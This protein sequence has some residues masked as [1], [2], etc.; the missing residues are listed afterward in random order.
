MTAIIKGQIIK[1][2]SKFAKNL[3]GDRIRLSTLKGE[4]NL[5]NLELDEEAL[6]DLLELPS[7]MVLTKAFCNKVSVKIPWTKLKTHPICIYLDQVEVELRTCE[8]PRTSTPSTPDAKQTPAATSKYGFVEKTVDGVFVSINAINGQFVSNT[9]KAD[10]QISRFVVQSVSPSTWQPTDLRMTRIK[11]Q[12]RGETLL[13]KMVEWSTIRLT[14]D[15]LDHEGGRPNTPIRIITNQG[16]IHITMKKKLSDC[17]ILASKLSVLLDDI[18]WVLTDSQIKAVIMHFRSLNPVIQKSTQQSKAMANQKQ[19][20]TSVVKQ[21]VDAKRPHNIKNAKELAQLQ[22]FEQYDL[23]ETSYHFCTQRIDLHLCDEMNRPEKESFK[24]RVDGGAMQLTLHKLFVDYYPFHTASASREHWERY[25]EAMKA[26]DKWVQA[27]LGH[28]KRQYTHARQ[29]IAKA[30]EQAKAAARKTEQRETANTNIEQNG[31]DSRNGTTL[32]NESV[33]ANTTTDTKNTNIQVKFDNTRKSSISLSD[34]VKVQPKPPPVPRT[35]PATKSIKLLA[36][37]AIIRISDF[38]I[39]NLSTSDRA[40][41]GSQSRLF[42]SDKKALFLPPEMSSVHIEYTSYYFPDGLDFPVPA[43][44]VFVQLN[45]FQFTLDY[46]TILWINQFVFNIKQSLPEDLQ[47]DPS[48]TIG[49]DHIDIRVDALMPKIIIPTTST[50]PEHPDRPESLL[51]QLSQLTASNCRIGTN[52]TRSELSTKLQQLYKSRLF[53]NN[54]Y[55]PNHVGDFTSLPQLLWDHAF[56]PNFF[57]PGTHNENLNQQEK[58]ERTESDSNFESKQES[59]EKKVNPNLK[60]MK[61]STYTFRE[62]SRKD[63]WCVKIDQIWADFVKPVEFKDRQIPFIDAV[64]LTIWVSFPMQL[65]DDKNKI[66][67]S[68][69]TPQKSENMPFSPDEK[70]CQM[71]IDQLRTSLL[72]NGSEQASN[73]VGSPERKQ[74]QN[75]ILNNKT[76]VKD[77]NQMELSKPKHGDMHLVVHTSEVVRLV[78]QHYQVLFLL[79]LQTSVQR[80]LQ[81]MEEDQLMLSAQKEIPSSSKIVAFRCPDIEATLLMAPAPSEDTPSED[82]S[83]GNSAGGLEDKDLTGLVSGESVED[84]NSAKPVN[85][86]TGSCPGEASVS[87]SLPSSPSIDTLSDSIPVNITTTSQNLFIEEK[88]NGEVLSVKTLTTKQT[89]DIPTEFSEFRERAATQPSTRNYSQILPKVSTDNPEVIIDSSN[90]HHLNTKPTHS[91]T[92]SNTDISNRDFP[93]GRVLYTS[94]TNRSTSPIMINSSLN[95]SYMMTNQPPRS[96]SH[97]DL[98]KISASSLSASFTQK[99][100]MLMGS[101]LSLDEVS[102]LGGFETETLSIQSDSSD[103]SFTFVNR[104]NVEM[105]SE[106]GLGSELSQS[107]PVLNGRSPDISSQSPDI[108]EQSAAVVEQSH[109]E[110]LENESADGAEQ[111]KQAQL[112]TEELYSN[113]KHKLNTVSVLK[114]SL[115]GVN[116]AVDLDN[117][118]M[119]ARIEIGAFEREEQGNMNYEQ[120]MSKRQTELSRKTSDASEREM[121]LQ[122]TLQSPVAKIR[123]ISGPGAEKFCETATDRGYA[124]LQVDGFISEFQKSTIS[125]LTGFVEDEIVGEAMPMKIELKNTKIQLQDD[126]P[127]VYITSPPP[128]PLDVNITRMTIERSPDGVFHIRDEVHDRTSDR[129]DGPLVFIDQEFMRNHNQLEMENLQ[130]KEQAQLMSSGISTLEQERASL[131]ATLEHLQEELLAADR[132]KEALQGKVTELLRRLMATKK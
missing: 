97:S 73:G 53:T 12:T 90:Q 74:D 30:Q 102:S 86:P 71:E 62:D 38:E 103:S 60:H 78:I 33:R 36:H 15:A 112:T 43:P 106:S 89:I 63:V 3:S 88:K 19:Q 39:Y 79:R 124:V 26:A 58:S 22:Y 80:L 116:V 20:T 119:A 8:E 52:S 55:F 34:E 76:D 64:P 69:E 95:V 44:N 114:V 16:Q 5:T 29:H 45:P 32:L 41:K 9:F 25:D 23:H 35:S 37:C 49:M 81:E 48:P 123:F 101:A 118:D 125:N 120:Y 13:F 132:Q 113:S 40:S 131:L 115:N 18:L 129:C 72:E 1:H 68:Q 107:L 21:E 108:I 61:L 70:K 117:N 10:I 105:D 82:I 50:V 6:M 59:D 66:S 75:T 121:L 24:R 7:W 85:S 65:N 31:P 128:I 17:D 77:V 46:T 27:I 14:I 122:A 98:A 56:Q 94:S 42:S 84:V 104:Q 54:L 111:S 126:M 99:Q 67:E 93:D 11:D 96:A 28:F 110:K 2:L 91:R 57:L 51:I 4:G 47:A 83:V 130:L 127:L 92:L 100:Q 87:S 109:D